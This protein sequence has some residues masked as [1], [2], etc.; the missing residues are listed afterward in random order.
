MA[1]FF[2]L[3]MLRCPVVTIFGGCLYCMSLY[4]T[5][6]FELFLKKK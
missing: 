2:F 1:F 6:Y 4:V 5:M 3:K